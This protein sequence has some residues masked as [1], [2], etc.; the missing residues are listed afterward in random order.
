[1][2]EQNF[3][4]QVR[5]K[6]DELSFVPSA[7]VWG[8]VEEQIR[9]KKEKRRI[10][11]WLLPLLLVSGLGWW[12][13]TDK[14]LPFLNKTE[15]ASTQGQFNIPIKKSSRD[16]TQIPETRTTDKNATEEQ[17]PTVKPNENTTSSTA[18][19]QTK[20]EKK[21]KPR[22]Q[23]A[24]LPSA[25]DL[26]LSEQIATSE[27][28]IQ[29]KV[30]LPLP[31]IMVYDFNADSI[32]NTRPISVKELPVLENKINQKTKSSN[33]NKWQFA[34][35]AQ[36]GISG[37]SEGFSSL[38]RSAEIY[39]DASPNTSAGG[40]FGNLPMPAP[41]ATP[42]SGIAFSA[43]LDVKRKINKRLA[44]NSGLRYAYYSNSIQV[45]STV[46]RDTSISRM[47][48]SVLRVAAFYRNDANSQKY[49]SEYHFIQIPF[50]LEY[51]LVANQPLYIQAGIKVEQLLGSNALFYNKYAGVYVKDKEMLAKTGMQL[52]SGF[53]YHFRSR[54]NFSFAA[55]P[56]FQYGLTNLS[57]NKSNDQHLYF[58]GLS[59]QIFLKKK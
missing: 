53:H 22:Q 49:T 50:G 30:A 58:V 14:G 12:L 37:I 13:F 4:K 18:I 29:N 2:Q 43:G 7:P 54:K 20:R 27:E 5:E 55:G 25:E 40:N 17:K 34:F 11:F 59:T 57:K 39:Y 38:G 1:M 23:P 16:I 26:F 45:G 31:E 15:Q 33:Q 19:I 41:P 28:E 47:D 9:N 32:L 21:T 36:G 8:K 46:Y 56:Q 42:K 10:I 24:G 3:E 51:K 52:F 35:A 6:M 48:A 44:L